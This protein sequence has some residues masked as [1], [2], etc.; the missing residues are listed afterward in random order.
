MK[1]EYKLHNEIDR[2][3]WDRCIRHAF[4]GIVYGYSWYLDIVSPGWTALV[5]GDYEMVMPV[6]ASRKWGMSY[7]L[8]PYFTQQLGLFSFCKLTPH[9]TLDFLNAIPSEF[10]FVNMNLNKFNSLPES[11][12]QTQK[13]V[14][15]EIDLIEPYKNLYNDYSTNTKR[16]IKKAAKENFYVYQGIQ[17]NDLINLVRDN[18][19]EKVKEIKEEDYNKMRQIVALAIRKRIGFVYGAYD[20]TNTLVAA[21]F[22]IESHNKSIFLFSASTPVGIQNSAMFLLVDQFIKKHSENNLTLDFEGS[23]IPGLARFYGGFGA[24]PYEFLKVRRNKLPFPLNYFY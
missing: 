20:T 11:K 5:G 9:H 13:G 4:N 23:S 14:T 15:Y 24:K 19:G 3:K 22:F 2:N 1:I 16:N 7:I 18:V 8:Q 21:A 12:F 17:P 10:R 6:T